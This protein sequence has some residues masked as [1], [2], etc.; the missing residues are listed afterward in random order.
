MCI[1]D[2]ARTH[3]RCYV[4]SMGTYFLFLLLNIGFAR[5]GEPFAAV[6]FMVAAANLFIFIFAP[7]DS[8]NKRFTKKEKR[9][10]RR[11]SLLFLAGI[12][13]LYIGCLT[14][15]CTVSYTHLDVYKRQDIDNTIGNIICNHFGIINIER[16]DSFACIVFACIGVVSFIITIIRCLI[17][18]PARCV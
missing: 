1:R 5:A 15:I 9:L 2:S 12:D 13:L 17:C 3:L 7:A 18:I 4:L 16:E 11:N 6:T 14:G 10:Y 8:E